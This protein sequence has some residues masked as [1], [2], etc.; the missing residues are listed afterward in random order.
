[1][2]KIILFA[3]DDYN[4]RKNIPEFLGMKFPDYDIE[5]FDDGIPLD[6]RL[7]QG[8]LENVCMVITDNQM[9]GMSGLEVIE[10]HAKRLIEQNIPMILHYGGDREIGVEAVRNGA[11]AYVLKPIPLKKFYPI[12]C[13]ALS[14]REGAIEE[15]S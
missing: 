11:Y 14:K 5:V 13:D 15:H 4:E 2:E 1:M 7:N 9:P 3:D 8:D 6:E 12:I 10:R